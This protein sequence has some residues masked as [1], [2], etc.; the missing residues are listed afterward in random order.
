[1]GSSVH[2]FPSESVRSMVLYWMALK[3]FLR[4]SAHSHSWETALSQTG[5]FQEQKIVLP[6]ILKAHLPFLPIFIKQEEPTSVQEH[7]LNLSNDFT[8][9]WFTSTAQSP[10]S[11]LDSLPFFHWTEAQVQ[12]ESVSPEP[13]AEGPVWKPESTCL[14]LPL[15]TIFTSQLAAETSAPTAD[16]RV[17][18]TPEHQ[19][20][21]C[22]WDLLLLSAAVRRE[23]VE[24]TQERA[25]CSPCPSHP[26]CPCPCEHSLLGEAENPRCSQCRQWEYRCLSAPTMLSRVC[27]V[28]TAL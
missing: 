5:A 25:W 1:M 7:L 4:L 26:S 11:H 27:P 23:K 19:P 12:P 18:G 9:I 21:G 6:R 22:Y 13:A 17:C 3:A 2:R 24:P 15:H 14:S 10:G 28:P 20:P 16:K 8:F